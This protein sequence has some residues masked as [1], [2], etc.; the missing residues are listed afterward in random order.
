MDER[1][2]GR[3]RRPECLPVGRCRP[4]HRLTNRQSRVDLRSWA[5]RLPPNRRRTLRLR[6]TAERAD[7]CH[8][9]RRTFDARPGG[10][11]RSPDEPAVAGAAGGRL[12]GATTGRH[13]DRRGRRGAEIDVLAVLDAAMSTGLSR[14]QLADAATRALRLRGII[15]VRRQLPMAT[16]LAQSPMESRT[17]YQIHR[18]GLPAPELQIAVPIPGGGTR[19]LDMGWRQK[20]SDWNL[21]GRNSIPATDPST[22]T[23]AAGPNLSRQGGP[24]FTSPRAMSTALSVSP[25]CCGA[26]CGNGGI[27]LQGSW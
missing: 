18:A 1:G 3:S 9:R 24:S 4:R 7:P 13:R 23:A 25:R 14:E 21:T 12:L 10:C 11:A 6:R 19:R 15:E 17:R 26:C 20:E 22:G 16:A 27:D 8:H 5:D 2:T